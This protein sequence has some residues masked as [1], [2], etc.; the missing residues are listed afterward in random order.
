MLQKRCI[1]LT[2]SRRAP[3]G[4]PWRYINDVGAIFSG[5]LEVR[6]SMKQVQAAACWV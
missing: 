5:L 3:C 4:R 6:L 2:R 1:G